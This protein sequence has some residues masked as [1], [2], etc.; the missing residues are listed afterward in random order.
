MLFQ[1]ELPE[2]I[3]GEDKSSPFK[4]RMRKNYRHVRKW[5]KRT[6]TDC[7]RIYDR[8]IK[9]YPFAID[10]YAGKFC[11]HYFSYEPETNEPSDRR[12]EEVESALAALFGA[13]RENI[14]WRTRMQEQTQYGAGPPPSG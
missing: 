3:D 4:N 12:V 13:T 8:D 5:A 10:F 2:I 11:V 9:E 14:Y 7:F 1:M 6:G